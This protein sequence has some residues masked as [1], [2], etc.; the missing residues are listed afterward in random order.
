MG[1]ALPAPGPQVVS[2][3]HYRGRDGLLP[4]LCNHLPQWRYR[5]RRCRRSIPPASSTPQSS[6][7]AAAHA[8][9]ASSQQLRPP[10][11]YR[12]APRAGTTACPLAAWDG[13]CQRQD[14]RS[15]RLVTIVVATAFFLGSAIICPNGGT[16][17]ATA[18]A[19]FRL[20]P[21]CRSRHLWQRRM[22]L[23]RRVSS[24]APR[25]ATAAPLELGR[26]PAR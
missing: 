7:T 19:A 4:R 22:P 16:A 23:L 11:R 5:T 21:R 15:Y 17:R 14:R 6:L 12:C 18:A 1:W 9:L 24:C 20:R 13:P 26:P 25:A 3:G 8:A 2:L 10:R